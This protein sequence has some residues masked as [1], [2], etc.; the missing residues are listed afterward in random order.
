MNDMKVMVRPF[1]T[2]YA[3]AAIIAL[4]GRVALAAAGCT[5][6]L[7]F[8]YISASGV[9]ILD[10][11]CSI[12]T[13]SAFVAFLFAAGL[14]L[15]VSTAGAVL[16]AALVARGTA[17]LRPLTA[18][19]WGWATALVAI[20]CLALVVLGILS[21]VQVGSMSSKLPGL[22][23]II[24]GVIGFAAFLGTLL[25]AASMVLCAC[26]ARFRAGHS[27]EASLLVACAGCGAVV[28]ALTLGTFS[29]LNAA[30]V[31]LPALGAWAAVDAIV[32]LVMLFG[33]AAYTGK[34]EGA[35]ATS[36]AP[37][38]APAA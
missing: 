12:L 31:S 17:R 7:A 25:G 34:L 32:N 30:T 35:I 1:L 24:A 3:L 33:A 21:A 11:I 13:G 23:V 19:L 20:A 28:G 27:L 36:A 2:L 9:P 18:F 26:V 10:V 29:V 16:Y 14:A 15:V 8:D 4:L 6:V 22:P 38:Q 37:R 5:G